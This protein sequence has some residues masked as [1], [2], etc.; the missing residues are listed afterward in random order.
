MLARI[1]DEEF[2]LRDA[3]RAKGV[4][5]DD[6]RAGFKEAAMDVAD[7]LR[8]RERKNIAVV[9]Q[10]FFRIFEALATNVRFRHA[11]G[12][13]GGAHRAVN[14]GDPVSEDLMERMFGFRH[15]G[16]VCTAFV[17]PP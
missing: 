2:A 12:A 1:I 6:V 10:I 14:D 13:D 3:R 4:G 9:Q 7:H 17:A 8:L 15:C 5:L 16:F 11:I